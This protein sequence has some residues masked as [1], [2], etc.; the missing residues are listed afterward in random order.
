MN[1]SRNWM[2]AALLAL[3]VA[4]FARYLFLIAGVVFVLA[5]GGSILRR[6]RT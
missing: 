3:I 6:E 2:I 5:V 4:I 1:N